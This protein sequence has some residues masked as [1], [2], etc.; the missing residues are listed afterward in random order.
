MTLR[1]S[2]LAVVFLPTKPSP[3]CQL[4]I[5]TGFVLFWEDIW[6]YQ[7]NLDILIE[8]SKMKNWC[9]GQ[10]SV[11]LTR[12][13]TVRGENVSIRC[14]VGKSWGIFF[15]ND[16]C[17]RIQYTVGGTAPLQMALGSYKQAGWASHGEQAGKQVP[18]FQFLHWLPSVVDMTWEC[19]RNKPFSPE[20]HLNHSVLSQ[21]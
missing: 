14:P 11:K 19:E 2:G 8:K 17:E 6:D 15:F 13:R 1:S 12:K 10:R 16:W 4:V 21:Q 9:P 3:W 7:M 5:L 20:I 18:L